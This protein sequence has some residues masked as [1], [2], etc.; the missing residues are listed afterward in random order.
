MGL[1]VIAMGFEPIAHGDDSETGAGAGIE[2]GVVDAESSAAE[3]KAAAMK[4]D[5][6]EAL[7][8]L[9]V[10][11]D[12]LA[13][14]TVLRID[15]DVSWDSVQV[16]GQRLEFGA[17]REVV[18]RRP[19]RVR[20]AGFRRSGEEATLYFD[21]KTISIDLPGE[22]AYVSL[23]RPGNLEQ[24]LDYLVD[25]MQTPIPLADLLDA[26]FYAELVPKVVSGFWVEE[27]S[28]GEVFCDHIALRG[29]GIDAQM[30]IEQ[31]DRPV[32]HRIVID[33]ARNR[34]APQF[35]ADITAWSFEPEAEDSLFVYEP[36]DG[37]ERIPMRAALEIKREE[38]IR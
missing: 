4:E 5:T 31:G 28:C 36:P 13:G 24:A 8:I 1:A 22:E 37:A 15:T 14:Q 6:A 12:F 10:M 17:H 25:D 23:E 18:M 3:A 34:G 2:V 20:I 32:P 29:D 35:R 30:W 11:S 9:K 27:S 33:Y 7:A 19:D 26:D 38:S 16:T 21:G